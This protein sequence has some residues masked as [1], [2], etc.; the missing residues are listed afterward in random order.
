MRKVKVDY[1]VVDIPYSGDFDDNDV[2]DLLDTAR[3]QCVVTGKGYEYCEYVS[4][5]VGGKL[6][7]EFTVENS[8]PDNHICTV[9][10][11]TLDEEYDG[12]TQEEKDYDAKCAWYDH[13][14]DLDDDR[15]LGID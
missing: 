2:Y 3:L 6:D 8:D 9:Y 11:S 1:F 5:K 4:E 13:L 14:Q 12:R 15:R 10:W 7:G